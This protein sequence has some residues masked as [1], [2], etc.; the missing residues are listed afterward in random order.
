MLR[1]PSPAI[2]IAGVL[3]LAAAG[4]LGLFASSVGTVVGV[5]GGLELSGT[6]A[7]VVA[8]IA[9][10]VLQAGWLLVWPS[11]LNVPALQTLALAT[12]AYVVPLLFLNELSQ[13]PATTVHVFL[14][15][16]V[17]G[18]VCFSVGLAVGNA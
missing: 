11:R 8:L 7:E 4:A 13:W 17:L 1:L 6:A 2:T 3:G 16:V 12:A 14:G 9:L 10:L 15:I 18:A 5:G